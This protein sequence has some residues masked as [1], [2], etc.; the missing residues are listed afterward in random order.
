[1]VDAVRCI[2]GYVVRRPLSLVLVIAASFLV[3]VP[4]NAAPSASPA[5]GQTTDRAALATARQTGE[6]VAIADRRTETADVY[7]N[8]D[9]TRTLVQHALPIRAKRN[10]A[11]TPLAAGESA[12][13]AG[14]RTAWTFV[15]KI[16]P[17]TAYFNS[18]DVAR[19]GHEN[20]SGN[21]VRSF[22]RMDTSAVKGAQIL[23]ASFSTVET[24]SWS[25][26]PRNVEVWQTGD[27]SATTTWLA[28]PA[29]LTRLSVVNVAKG[30]SAACPAGGVEFNVLGG[31]Q[32]AAA[33]NAD[34]LTLGLRATSETDTYAWKR[35]NNN[36]TLVIQY[37][38]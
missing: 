29:W 20:E 25:C 14:G 12:Y 27:I 9:G 11:W 1:M 28:Q 33:A 34:S 8:P 22:F 10:G 23:S 37:V 2:R 15:S 17:S 16:Y 5:V 35:F 21:T 18:T 30:Y 31:V 32:S 6:S 7:A 4:A 38:A 26:S 19:V 24:H 13:V 36:P 3:A